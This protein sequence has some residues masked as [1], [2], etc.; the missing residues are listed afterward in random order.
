M[1]SSRIHHATGAV[2]MGS[3]PLRAPR[4]VWIIMMVIT[5]LISGV[6]STL[7]AMQKADRQIR[8]DLLLT[9]QLIAQSIPP[10]LLLNLSARVAQQDSPSYLRLKTQLAAIKSTYPDYAAI[11]LMGLASPPHTTDDPAVFFFISSDAPADK[12]KALSGTAYVEAPEGL[13]YAFKQRTAILEGPYRDRWG[14][15]I[16]AFVPLPGGAMSLSETP[17]EAYAVLGVDLNVTLW[18]GEIIA[19][20]LPSLL[21][22]LI[23]LG[24]L[25]LGVWAFARYAKDPQT[26]P[27]KLRLLAVSLAVLAGLSVTLFIASNAHQD[28]AQARSAS[29]KTLAITK[30]AGFLEDMRG[31][32]DTELEGLARFYETQ[33]EITAAQFNYYSAYLLQNPAI[34]A[35]AWVPAITDAQRSAFEQ[36]IQAQGIADFVIWEQNAHGIRQSAAQRAQYFP[37]HYITAHHDTQRLLGYDMGSEGLRREALEYA[38]HTGLAT[39][40]KPLTL[41]KN[42]PHEQGVLIYRPVF[43][44]TDSKA[45]RGFVVAMLSLPNLLASSSPD[46]TVMLSL[47]LLGHT[48]P[49]TP[50]AL[51][52][53]SECQ[54][55]LSLQRPILALGNAFV[56]NAYAGPAFMALYPVRAV[57]LTGIMGLCLTLALAA[58]VSAVF[59]RRE[60]LEQ[61]VSERTASLRQSEAR[62]NHLAQQSRTI[63]WETDA[64][65]RYVYVSDVVYEVLG[66]PP[67][68]LIGIKPFEELHAQALDSQ[69]GEELH[70][71]WQQGRPFQ[72]LELLTKTR[73]GQALWLSCNGIPLFDEDGQLRGYQGAD[74][75]ITPRKETEQEIFEV[76]EA[77]KKQMC[78]A[79]QMAFQAEAANATKTE[80]L[81]NIS[82]ELRTP[83]NGVIGMN[84]LL[85][86]TGLTEEQ[87]EYA[88]IVRNSSA[89]MMGMINDILD[90]SRIEAGKLELEVLDFD[91]EAMLGDLVDITALRAYDKGL[92]LF[93]TL[94]PGLPR[95]MRG[96]PGRLRQILSNLICNA[97]KFTPKGE[98][99]IRVA[100]VQ[101]Q[102]DIAVLRFAVRDTG[103]GIPPDKLGQLFEK[104]TQ[105]DSSTT[106][107]YGGMGLGLAIAKQLTEMMHGEIGVV[108]EAGQGSEF[109]FTV[110]LEKQPEDLQK[111]PRERAELKGARVLVLDASQGHGDMLGQQLQS[112][113]MRITH[114]IDQPRAFER[115]REAAADDPFHIML[116]NTQMSRDEGEAISSA[117]RQ[118][119]RLQATRLILLTPLGI[120]G[121]ARYYET[122]GFAAYLTKPV[123]PHE[124][125]GALSLVLAKPTTADASSTLNAAQIITRHTVR[126][127]IKRFADCKARILLVED[128]LINQRMMMQMLK[129]LG[130][131]A[132][133]VAHGA[134][135]LNALEMT[136]YD[137]VIM[138]VK[139]PIMD[140]LEATRQIRAHATPMRSSQDIPIIAI[141]AHAMHLDREKCLQAGMNDYLAKPITL[142]SLIEVL[143]H[144]LS[145]ASA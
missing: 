11:Y 1:H 106:R 145:P 142:H 72:N 102:S 88:E 40:S 93:Y 86:E 49:A 41:I 35:W 120:R 129:K 136:H 24:I 38:A 122:L 108:S 6:L 34:D 98:I 44:Q 76:N 125:Q 17:P 117:L 73:N 51:S 130:L 45:L 105:V 112:W 55:T 36:Q 70:T 115:L 74:T 135:A 32:L 84:G 121:D 16:S 2:N 62:F 21:V 111:S 85:L 87:R 116:V 9:T 50:L 103:I 140:G 90:V 14:Q 132:D 101:Q 77:L 59:L 96:D 27:Y 48:A 128:N 39:S 126:E 81:A 107:R 94:E 133:A 97:I 109:W 89:L 118:E 104:F 8:E 134:E 110:R 20:G 54:P 65:G 10:D 37:I 71:L 23:L 123:K 113:G 57:W 68:E 131:R 53:E 137:L 19:A 31:I 47:S 15:W 29:F 64:Q 83:M 78:L 26:S 75:D 91:L 141:T 127:A 33:T 95:H 25:L 79:T 46:E 66:Y 69:T 60:I 144:Y 92:E 139:M 124:L 22:M 100:C 61:K 63:I 114:V 138:D 119:P 42:F 28:E 143:D 12:T 58:V 18:R 67:G 3:P 56:L 4:R 80:F 13:R 52:W 7:W 99:A 43:H 82:H 30:T 5:V